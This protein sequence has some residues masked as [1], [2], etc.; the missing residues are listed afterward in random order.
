MK[1]KIVLVFL[2]LVVLAAVVP[3]AR[4][5]ARRDKELELNYAL[6]RETQLALATAQPPGSVM[7]VAFSPDGK[8]LGSAGDDG[9]V[10]LWIVATHQPLGQSDER[11]HEPCLGCGV[12]SRR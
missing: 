4:Y 6:R 9:T 10:R 2:G 8:V 12:Q 3:L 5:K 7:S 11:P 1:K